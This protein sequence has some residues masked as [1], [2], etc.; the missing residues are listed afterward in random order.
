MAD[1]GDKETEI[2]SDTEKKGPKQRKSSWGKLRH[3]DS[4]N[5]EAGR[6]F[7]SDKGL[8]PSLAFQS[9]GIVYGDLGTS[10]LYT[11]AGIFPES[12]GHPDN[13]LGALSLILYCIILFPLV[14]YT[15]V[16]LN[17]NDYGEGGTFA[18]YSLLCRH[19]RVSLVPNQQPEDRDLSNYKLETPSS[20]L[21]RA[22]YIRGK[23][24]SSEAVKIILLLV[25]LLG[26]SMVIGDGIVT[27]SISEAVV[28]FTVLILFTLFYA[29]QFGTDKVGFSFAPILTLWF[30]LLIGIGFYNLHAY[31]FGVL[32]AVN[33]Y[34][35]VHYFRRRGKEGWRS[36]GGVV[37]S[38]TGTEAMFA[39]LG[40][41]SVR[42][43]Q[44][45]FSFV[46][47]PSILVAYC[48][49]AAYLTE[50]PTDVVDTFYRSIPGPMYWPAFVIAVLAS[51]I[52]SQAMISGVFSI[53]TQS[54]SLACFPKVKVVHTSAK[55]EGQVYIPEINY[56]ILMIA[57]ILVTVGFKTTENIRHA[58][59]IAV[60]AVMIITTGM[61]ALIMLIIW[62]TNIF[63]V[64]LFCGFYGIIELV[65]FT[66]VLSKFVQG[67]FLPIVFAAFM[68]GIMGIWHYVHHKRY[69]FELRNKVSSEYMTQLA[70]DP[71]INRVPGMGLLCSELV[72][73]IPP[74]F[75]HF[76]SNIPSIHSV[77]VFLSLKKLPVS[78]ISEEVRLLFRHVDP[79]E[80]RMFH[81]IVRYGYMDII[82]TNEEFEH[83][84]LERFKDFIRKEYLIADGGARNKPP[85]IERRAAD[86]GVVYLLGEAHV[87]AKQNSYTLTK[88]NVYTFRR[89]N[90]RQGE[91]QMMQTNKKKETTDPMLDTPV[92][93]DES[94]V[95]L[96]TIASL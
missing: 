85:M 75:P 9:I 36:L 42:A 56:N 35:I 12:I 47:M 33:P 61:L 88:I 52:A 13:L 95:L 72:H 89:N 5:L 34:Y 27:P 67:G 51:V 38:T 45:S 4:L 32:R 79:R 54:L 71:R 31:G 2:T 48:G 84:L 29:Q 78:K 86:G 73:G 68:M 17:A 46:V 24:E 69:D 53:I 8:G 19:V 91:A 30:L 64:I 74:I 1:K 62:R 50:H 82:G 83:Q 20:Q 37:L 43:I 93:L 39:D 76:I 40:H 6:I 66:S 7:S 28:G 10:P 94:I 25:T 59:G 87:K 60:V 18:L 15:F 44:L 57:C 49:Q 23:L 55:Y 16:V 63:W 70:K 96:L 14:K 22:H 21:K 81:C 80:Y 11:F 26:T 3:V 58:Y 92:Y 41:F 65:L 77:L 90:F